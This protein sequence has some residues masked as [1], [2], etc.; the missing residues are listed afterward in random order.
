VISVF[1]TVTFPG[2]TIVETVRPGE[3]Y[4]GGPCD[5]FRAV[6]GF[7][8]EED[9]NRVLVLSNYSVCGFTDGEC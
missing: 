5:G 6:R 1:R 7:D 9:P 4:I 3:W 2:K 8:G